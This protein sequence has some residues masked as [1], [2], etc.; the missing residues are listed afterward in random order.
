[1]GN[2]VDYAKNTRVGFDKQPLN[3]VDSLILSQLSYYHL[4]TA[5]KGILTWEGEK[6][7]ALPAVCD[8]D[9]MLF[10]VWD[11]QQSRE[12]LEVAA[13]NPRYENILVKGYEESTNAKDEKQF[14]AVTFQLSD[15]LF[16]VAFRGTDSTLIGWKEN[17][18]MAYRLPVPSQAEAVR[19][20]K[21]A[22][23]N[24][25]GKI[26][27]GGHSKGGNLAVYAAAFVGDDGVKNRLC[28]V[29]SHD[30]PGFLPDITAKEEY[31]SIE[32]LIDKTVPGASLVGML[33]DDPAT[34]N[35]VKSGRV[36]VL[37]H[38]PFSWKVSGG[39]F[40]YMSELS[41]VARYN[42]K[43]LN[44]W[45]NSLSGEERRRLVNLIFDFL[46][47]QDVFTTFD[48]KD[49]WQK[50]VF[51]ALSGM[52]K[53]D[54]DAKKFFKKSVKRLASIGIKNIPELFKNKK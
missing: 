13:A 1:M 54:K 20:L 26:Y 34:F 37:Q 53:T 49:S 41:G 6:L 29:Y 50:S 32:R 25:K 3:A 19:Y 24:C 44:A 16:Y 15:D 35:V 2:I 46:D 5:A 52:S 31:K 11:P 12:L 21:D 17:F 4:P 47:S 43:T 14:A 8:Y 18:N 23:E 42:D 27:V 45:I 30:G 40:V 22:A 9:A 10:D 36:G 48:L 28:K 51:I 33:L 39:E 7:S 38:D